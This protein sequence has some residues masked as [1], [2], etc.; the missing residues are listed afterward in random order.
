MTQTTPQTIDC[1]PTWSSILP[2]LI[3]LVGKPRTRKDAMIEIKR[4]AEMAD[5]Y[6]AM[7]K[8]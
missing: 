7:L 3:E 4:M 2:I 8:K 1:A 6:I 5:A